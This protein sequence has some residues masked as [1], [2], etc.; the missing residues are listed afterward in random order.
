YDLIFG[1][2]GAEYLGPDADELSAE[3]NGILKEKKLTV[4]TAESFTAGR[5]ASAII[6]TP[7]ASAVFIEGIVAYSNES[8]VKRLGVSEKTLEKSGAVSTECC[9]EMLSGLIK[10]SGAE[11]AISS[12]G[13]AGPKSD[14][15]KK[16]V[17]LCFIGI[18]AE[19]RFYIYKFIFEGDRETITETAVRAAFHIAISRLK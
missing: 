9:A 2:S 10:G 17:G 11:V 13:I 12:T 14:D 16:P 7:G 1:E 15:T 3:L 5:I 6:K 8:K 4:A 19:K 18:A